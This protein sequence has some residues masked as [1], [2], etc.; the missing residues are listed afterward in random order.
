MTDDQRTDGLID[1]AHQQMDACRI[2]CICGQ[3]IY[4]TN[5]NGLYTCELC[6]T[7]Y[8]VHWVYRNGHMELGKTLAFQ[9]V[10]CR[11]YFHDSDMA[12][13][14]TCKE[15]LSPNVNE[16]QLQVAIAALE[17][18]EV[19][20][21]ANEIAD[22]CKTNGLEDAYFSGISWRSVFQRFWRKGEVIK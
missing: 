6:A 15:C 10:E 2:D 19:D 8:F 18:E 1:L 20:G 7:G 3:P 22:F 9:C 4:A 11:C 12:D 13:E 5:G 17:L 14:D 16:M 21:D